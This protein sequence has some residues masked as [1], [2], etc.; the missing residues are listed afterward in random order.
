MNKGWKFRA[1]IAAGTLV[2]IG[3]AQM[4]GDVFGLPV[5]KGLAQATG[6]SPMPKVFTAHQGFETYSSEFFLAWTD[7]SGE[8]HKLKLTPA[9]YRGVRGP[10]KRRNAYGAAISYAPV[11]HSSEVTRPMLESVLRFAFCGS[12][13][14][15]EEL[16]V[17]ADDVAGPVSVIIEPR[18]D[19]PAGHGWKLEF[20]SRCDAQ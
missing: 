7:R 2:L 18:Q 6:S 15:L 20:E 13:T 16:G 14:I 3:V 19:L 10:Y 8:R 1:W 11:L 12:S 5:L 4:I 17:D 9:N